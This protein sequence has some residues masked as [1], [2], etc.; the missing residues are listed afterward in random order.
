[1]GER[2]ERMPP[3]HPTTAR[4]DSRGRY[5]PAAGW[6]PTATSARRRG[7]G[8][9]SSALRRRGGEGAGRGH[10]LRH[11]AGGRRGV[12]GTG[13]RGDTK[14]NRRGG[15]GKRLS[16]RPWNWYRSRGSCATGHDQFP[17]DQD[18]LKAHPPGVPTGTIL[19]AWDGRLYSSGSGAASP[20]RPKF[21]RRLR[22]RPPR[23][24]RRDDNRRHSPPAPTRRAPSTRPPSPRPRPRFPP[25]TP[26]PHHLAAAAASRRPPPVPTAAVAA[27]T[28][29]GGS[30]RAAAAAAAALHSP[31][32]GSGM[33]QGAMRVCGPPSA[34]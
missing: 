17:R 21:S 1:M 12:A 14:R 18:I 22:P 20:V 23:R 29:S 28:G 8:G 19:T 11:A 32:A 16:G 26:L 27:A 34:A 2:V 33:G 31:S 30:Q 24:P 3:R 13:L 4:Q 6:A 15:S 10:R 25:P 5:R 7:P 9:A